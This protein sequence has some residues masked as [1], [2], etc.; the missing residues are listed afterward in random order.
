MTSLTWARRLARPRPLATAL[1][2]LGLLL[3]KAPPIAAQTLTDPIFQ[4]PLRRGTFDVPA[5]PVRAQIRLPPPGTPA[6]TKFKSL[7]SWLEVHA[8]Q[9]TRY[10]WADHRYRPNEVGGD[11]MFAFRTRAQARVTTNHFIGIAE[12]Q[13]SRVGMTDS[14]STISNRLV[15]NTKM[16]Q[17]SAGVRWRD[18][19]P[20][21]LAVQIEAGRFSRDYGMGR[22][23]SRLIYANTTYIQ[24]GVVVGL[25][26]KNWTVQGLALRPVTY[27]YPNVERDERYDRARLGGVYATTTRIPHATIDGYYLHLND[28]ADFPAATRRR[29]ETPGVRVLGNFGPANRI[30]YEGETAIQWGEVGA[31]THRAWFEHV[32]AGLAWPD[33]KFRPRLLGLVDYATGDDD[34]TDQRSGAFDT[35]YGRVRFE[36][37]PTSFYGLAGRSNLL[38]PGL[39]L[40]L[41]PSNSSELSIQQRWLTLASAR[42]RWRPIG[43]GDPTGAA[44]TNLGRQVEV[45]YRH[46]WRQYMDFD[47]GVAHF[48]EGDFVR[49]VRPMPGGHTTFFFAGTEWRF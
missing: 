32:Q 11:E 2:G 5:I 4:A 15:F 27:T 14:A 44:G 34:P 9:R 24:D 17:L 40:I 45:R 36:F 1:L 33:V 37:G 29:L 7:P 21:K 25:R 39:W 20:A 23:I 6:T 8:E 13:D 26:S 35:L 42:D 49:A 47:A 18:L 12:V 41:R 16:S 28:G 48:T 22:L 30:E 3:V 38:S 31:L 46:R 19:G 43:V 10:E